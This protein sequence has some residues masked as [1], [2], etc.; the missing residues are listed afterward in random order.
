MIMVTGH[1]YTKPF[2]LFVK[3]TQGWSTSEGWF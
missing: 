1:M 3:N 2:I